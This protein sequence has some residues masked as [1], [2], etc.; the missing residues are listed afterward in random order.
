MSWLFGRRNFLSAEDEAWHFETWLWFLQN[1]GGLAALR[2]RKTVNA[3][4][5]FFPPTEA[6]GHARAEH[7]FECVKQH[8][9]MASW[10]CSLL[11]QPKRPKALVGQYTALRPVARHLPLGTFLARDGVA[12]ISYDPDLLDE[13]A[14]MVSTLAHELAHYLLYNAPTE[15]PGGEVMHEYATDLA[16]VFLGFGL[17]GANRAFEFSQHGDSI[18]QGW[19]MQSRGYLSERDWIFGLA[20]YVTLRD[21]DPRLLKTLLKPHLYDGLRKAHA[22]LA[23]NASYLDAHRKRGAATP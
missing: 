6:T 13:P 22:Y 15:P 8:A 10:P 4:R 23:K 14:V 11:E 18:S 7:I 17:F 19:Q 9:G 12:T 5:E 2:A 3:T 20:V 1:F 16:T 21:E